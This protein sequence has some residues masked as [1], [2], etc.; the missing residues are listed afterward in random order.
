[1]ASVSS[2]EFDSNIVVSR[3]VNAGELKQWVIVFDNVFI[4][5]MS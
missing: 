2:L 5:F 1:M 4:S 3:A